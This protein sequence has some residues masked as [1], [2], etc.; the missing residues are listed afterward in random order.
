METIELVGEIPEPQRWPMPMSR[1]GTNPFGDPLYRVV[2]APSVRCMVGGEF[3]DG[4]TGYRIRPSY[5]HIGN[6]W[7][8][9]KWLSAIDFTGLTEDQYYLKFKDR[10]TGLCISGPYP[11]RGAYFHCHT[12]ENSQPGDGG[13]EWLIGVLNKCA[14][15]DPAS[16]RQALVDA[17]EKKERGDD[18][19][20]YDRVKELMPAFGIRAASYRGH[21]KATKTAPIIRSANELGLPLAG[22]RQI[23]GRNGSVQ[24][25]SY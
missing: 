17:Q 1:Y 14:T 3:A 12:F 16:V 23:G 5:R 19:A 13:I 20:R 11:S 8:M 6:Q 2:F 18:A 4:H 25:A 10:W 21:V 7:I 9:E 24:S 15:N 22:P